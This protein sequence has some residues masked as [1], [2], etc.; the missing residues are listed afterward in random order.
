MIAKLFDFLPFCHIVLAG[1]NAFSFHREILL[2][3]KPVALLKKDLRLMI[4]RGK[5]SRFEGSE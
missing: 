3:L 5:G 4:F 2:S 1:E